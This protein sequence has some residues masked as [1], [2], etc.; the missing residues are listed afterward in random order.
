MHLNSSSA[1][2]LEHLP[3]P[4]K[5]ACRL[6][7]QHPR[8]SLTSGTLIG[9]T[10]KLTW[11]ST[12]RSVRNCT[13]WPNT[14]RWELP[15]RRSEGS[16]SLCSRVSPAWRPTASDTHWRS[17]WD[18]AWRTGCGGPAESQGHPSAKSGDPPAQRVEKRPVVCDTRI[19]KTNRCGGWPNRWWE[20][21]LRL[22][23]VT[24]GNSLSDRKQKP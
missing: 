13:R 23:L 6:S 11:K 12:F 10:S 3:V 24:Q 17:E 8:I 18:N 14:L 2:S 7:F 22:P 16:S 4:S 1:L 21:L 9:P 5:T 19:P 15:R 20:F